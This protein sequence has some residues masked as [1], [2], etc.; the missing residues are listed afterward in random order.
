MGDDLSFEEEL[1]LQVAGRSRPSAKSQGKKRNRRAVSISDDD[2]D[3]DAEAQGDRDEEDVPTQDK[4]PSSGQKKRSRKDAQES[5]QV[6]DEDEF[7]DGYGSDLMGDEEDRAN[8]MAMN[9]L[10]REMILAERAEK[11][12]LERERLRNAQLL[13][14]HQ[15]ASQQA[16]QPRASTRAKQKGGAKTSAMAELV[17]AKAARA[18]RTTALD[19]NRRRRGRDSSYSE[20][21]EA[22]L[23]DSDNE[24]RSQRSSPDRSSVERGGRSEDSDRYRQ[25]DRG[26]HYDRSESDSDDDRDARSQEADD[27]E[28]APMDE[29]LRMQVR[30]SVLAKWLDEP[31]LEKTVVGC[32]VRVTSHGAYIVAEIIGVVEREPGT[33]RDHGPKVESPYTIAE[34]GKQTNKWLLL[35]HG[36]AQ[37]Y[38]PIAWVSNKSFEEHE[39][40][41]WCRQ[42]QKDNRPQLSMGD[43]HSAVARFKQA[44]SYTYTAQDVQRMLDEKRA[45]GSMRNSA[46]EKARLERLREA[47]VDKEDMEEANRLGQQI[48]EL[49]MLAAE[50]GADKR[51]HNTGMASVNKKNA[52][53]NFENAFKNVGARPEGARLAA[54]G[55]DPFS[56]RKTR[57]MNYWATKARGSDDAPNGPGQ[58]L[59]VS[60][61]SKGGRNVDGQ[62]ETPAVAAQATENEQ[63]DIDVNI[64]LTV[65]KLA[66]Q[67]NSIATQLLGRTWQMSSCE[68]AKPP[69]LAARKTLT[70][71]DY[72]RRAGIA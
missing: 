40:R 15:Q 45:R 13:R 35:Q 31:F 29:A 48:A 33:Y 23:S 55:V 10:Q 70:L 43:V 4:R 71:A 36:T 47:A 9:E 38:M 69:D 22:R 5:E 64:D 52:A 59:L 53:R 34:T 37:K 28:E 65:L 54:D 11:R 63:G 20:E 44:L 12:D 62:P 6:S 17:A 67:R 27:S 41:K 57:P 21:D 39:W 49:E 42:C 16:M 19:R 7:D 3:F 8:L 30:R 58:G 14:Q 66:A 2:D 25:E 50:R 26:R 72:K 32:L 61:S 18:E 1:L 46:A 51:K 56:R 60:T 24:E 68:H